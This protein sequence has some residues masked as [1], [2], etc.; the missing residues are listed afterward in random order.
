MIITVARPT[1]NWDAPEVYDTAAL[2]ADLEQLLAGAPI[3]KKHFDFEREE[4]VVDGQLQ[5]SPFVIVEGI[6]AGSH[7]L[8]DVLDLHFNVP[9]PVATTVGRDL[10]RLMHSDRP[11]ASIGS[12]EARLRYQLETAIP[13]YRAQPRPTRNSWSASVRPITPT[14]EA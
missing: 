5:P 10:M 11:N 6:F 1:S 12:P 13:T 9:T 3:D 14:Y 7:H 2:A 4:V 8:R